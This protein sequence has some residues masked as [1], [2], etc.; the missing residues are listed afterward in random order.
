MVR[1][2]IMLSGVALVLAACGADEADGPSTPEPAAE[3]T[4]SA[5]QT[6]DDSA[7][8]EEPGESVAEVA[9]PDPCALYVDIDVAALISTQA[10]DLDGSDDECSIAAA[11]PLEFAITS[12]TLGD[13]AAM[14]VIRNNYEGTLYECDVVDVPDLGDEAFSCLRGDASSH[15]VFATGPYLVVFS[16]GNNVAG[17]P[18]DSLMMEAAAQI[19]ANMSF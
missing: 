1:I 5:M 13:A 14:P 16:A 3:V 7:A 2:V 6:P 9:A 10:G 12:V 19:L 17:P 11:D 15:V 18:E 8:A 4:D